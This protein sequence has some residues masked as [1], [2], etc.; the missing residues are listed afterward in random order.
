[1]DTYMY[2]Q[3]SLA[4]AS[5]LQPIL[6]LYEEYPGVGGLNISIATTIALCINT[7]AQPC[8]QLPI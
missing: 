5:Q 4:N 7:L 3:H 8:D 6:V 1:M 2:S